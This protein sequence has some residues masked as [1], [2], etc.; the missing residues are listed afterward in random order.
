MGEFF[1]DVIAYQGVV[2]TAPPPEQKQPDQ[3]QVPGQ[4]T[5]VQP[6]EQPEAS[7]MFQTDVPEVETKD[8][9]DGLPVF[10]VE[11]DEFYQNMN[12]GRKRIRFK[13]GSAASEY[14]KKTRYHKPFYIKHGEYLR[15]IK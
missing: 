1:N 6:P 11:K 2:Q 9:R 10:E 12:H 7:R 3:E 14:M 15:K 13:S 8:Q 5:P 4:E